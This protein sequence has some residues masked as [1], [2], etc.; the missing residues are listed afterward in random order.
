MPVLSDISGGALV[1]TAGVAGGNAVRLDQIASIKLDSGPAE[2]Q[3]SDRQRVISVSGNASGRPIGDLARDVRA[4]TAGIPLP[5]GY[6][7][8]YGGQVQQQETAFTTLLST[9]VLSVL[10][11]YMLMV[12]LYE[13][14][15]TPLAILFSVPVALV[16]AIVGL[17]V[18]QNTFNI[19]SLIG[20]IMLMGLVGKNA[21]LLVDYTNT[22]RARGLGRREALLEA[23][24]TRL[25]P[26]MMTTATVV[27]AMIPLALK[28]ESGGESR[29]PMAVVIIGGVTSST[30]L[31]LVLVPVMYT[32]LEDA[33]TRVSAVLAWRPGRHAAP[34][35]AHVPVRTHAANL[36]ETRPIQ[37]G[38][39]DD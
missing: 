2:I 27:C 21:I 15:L 24:Y 29:A 1:N 14:F 39:T 17:W 30:L 19:F 7:V 35:P 13:S 8:V 4:A 12:A 26:I 3:R 32:L 31:S 23:G 11:V 20:C 34:R 5:D 36:A 18:T 25:R 37:G 28:L 38:A 6:R 16:G 33:K 22:L 9:L 10:L